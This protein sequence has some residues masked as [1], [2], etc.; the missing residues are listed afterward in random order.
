MT[1]RVRV[2]A[3]AP[4][5]VREVFAA[6]RATMDRRF[7]ELGVTTS[8]S[9]IATLL[10]RFVGQ[11]FE[12]DVVIDADRLDT[13]T[14]DDLKQAFGTAHE[15]VYFSRG[16][17]AGKALEIVGFRLG[18]SA[19]E[20]TDIP[21]DKVIADPAPPGVCE[22]YEW[23]AHHC[24]HVASRRQVAAHGELNGPL[25]IEDETATIYVPPGWVAHND[26]TGNLILTRK[27]AS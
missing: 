9:Y 18:A 19:P 27:E 20:M 4:A 15:Q 7:A 10:M 3:A 26:D 17:V 23:R 5:A 8:C 21:R 24:C 16:G 25:L 2:D 1:R 22:L 12:L 11:A 14:G 13:L 6:Q